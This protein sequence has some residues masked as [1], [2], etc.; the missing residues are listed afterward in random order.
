MARGSIKTKKLSKTIYFENNYC[1]FAAVIGSPLGE[2]KRESGERPE[3][4]PAG[5][6]LPMAFPAAV[7]RP[8]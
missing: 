2:M 3:Q 5:R 4:N 8:L 7:S 1:I 6:R